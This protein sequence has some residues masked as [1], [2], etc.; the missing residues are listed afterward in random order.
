MLVFKTENDRIRLV[1]KRLDFVY[2]M[3]YFHNIA[4]NKRENKI[5]SAVPHEYM[6]GLSYGWMGVTVP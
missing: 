1:K 4:K 3:N 6:Y 2:G 5:K